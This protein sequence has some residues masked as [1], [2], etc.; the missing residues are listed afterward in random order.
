MTNPTACVRPI[1]VAYAAIVVACLAL[2]LCVANARKCRERVD[3]LWIE[4]DARRA[5]QRAQPSVTIGEG[6]TEVRKV[7]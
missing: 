1:V 3:Q 6:R 7:R 4:L 2:V 5:W